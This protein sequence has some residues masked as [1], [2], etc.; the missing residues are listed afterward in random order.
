[1]KS[2]Y[3]FCIMTSITPGDK[4]M[5]KRIGLLVLAA[6]ALL[7]Q[8]PA[9]EKRK[10]T[11]EEAVQIGLENSKAL[12][13]SQNK[14][15]YADARLSETNAS[16]LLSVKGNANYTRLSSV[17][18]AA[19]DI[20]SLTGG[21]SRLVT[22]S[23]NVENSYTLRLS[24]QHPLFMGFRLDAAK[25]AASASV[26]GAESDLV[27]DKS[28]LVYNVRAAY[29][30]L[31]RADQFLALANE[32]VAQ[33]RSHL[34][35]VANLMAQGLATAND[36][37]TVAVQLSD[38]Q[39]RQIDAKNGL[40]MAGLSLNNVL[41]IPLGTEIE[42]ASAVAH[43]PR[44][45]APIDSLVRQGRD[46]RPDIR[47]LES[48]IKAGEAGVTAARAGWFPQI[49]LTGNYTSARPNSRIFPTQDVFKDT[50]D[51][52]VNVSLDIWNWGTTI[53]Q[54]DQAQAQLAQAREALGLTEDAVT[55]DI[56]QAYLSLQQAAERISV[57]TT[58]VARAEE[59][60]RVTS[61]RYKE[62]LV[63]NSDMLDAEF[64][65]T[66]AKTNYTQALVDFELAQAR[67]ARAI[68][69]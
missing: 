53:H 36:T 13:L 32:N 42:I 27:K 37:L 56:T 67:L 46:A 60:F 44:A 43:N 26:E 47:S 21:P 54:T 62:G 29:W 24:A 4:M 10:L 64:T 38:A 49:M 39:L 7:S 52:G 50:W 19:F 16:A 25:D 45:F 69:E 41:G 18:A 30:N 17:P 61:R 57:A 63:I 2:H 66:S 68:G 59:N 58:T 3:G 5:M 11:I 48:R 31:Y 9:Q 12:R 40:R 33:I 23:Q 14:V 20:S 35:D 28:D 55:L 51:V 8:A 22:L 1:M 15:A 6:I 65:R 34:N